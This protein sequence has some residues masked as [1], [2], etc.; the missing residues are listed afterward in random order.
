MQKGR[1]T[2]ATRLDE[3]ALL[4]KS[5]NDGSLEIVEIAYRES[6]WDRKVE[7]EMV[8]SIL[9]KLKALHDLDFVHGDI[10]LVNLL[11]EFRIYCGL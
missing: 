11:N 6:D 2:A 9:L 3:E 1:D 4:W 10:R 7:E 8:V 5:E